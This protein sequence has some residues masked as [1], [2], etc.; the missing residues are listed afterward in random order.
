M[1]RRGLRRT[2]FFASLRKSERVALHSISVDRPADYAVMSGFS[3]A[4]AANS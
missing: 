1:P 3:L 4:E 2:V